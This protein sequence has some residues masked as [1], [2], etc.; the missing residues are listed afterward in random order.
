LELAWNHW[1]GPA[2]GGQIRPFK[3]FIAKF[4]FSLGLRVRSTLACGDERTT[5]FHGSELDGVIWQV[6]AFCVAGW[7]RFGNGGGFLSVAG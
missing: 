1:F 6:F 3:G 2:S 4:V 7:V 5:Y